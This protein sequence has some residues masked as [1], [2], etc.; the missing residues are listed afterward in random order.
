[1]PP[2]AEADAD[3]TSTWLLQREAVDRVARHL[4]YPT[5]NAWLRIVRY[6]RAGRIKAR[7]RTAEG[8]LISLLPAAWREE[9]GEATNRELLLDDLIAAD[10]LPALGDQEGRRSW[11]GGRR[12]ARMR[13]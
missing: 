5:E 8:W 1:M 3:S 10:L 9:T 6:C 2:V 11:R 13:T 7:D 4:G 12:V